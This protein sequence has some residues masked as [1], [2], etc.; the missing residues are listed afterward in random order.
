M[1]PYN[2]TIDIHEDSGRYLQEYISSN[3]N[4]KICLCLITYSVV[5][6]S[7]KPSE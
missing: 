7:R 2:D 3:L 4:G 5:I 1:D 6:S